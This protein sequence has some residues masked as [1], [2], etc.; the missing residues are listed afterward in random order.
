M[1]QRPILHQPP[2]HMQGPPMQPN[3]SPWMINQPPPQMGHHL[4][5]PPTHAPPPLMPQVHMP[6]G[7]PLNIPP[8]NAPIASVV[9]SLE[10]LLSQQR[11]LQE[12][13]QQSEQNL[14]AQQQVWILEKWKYR[15]N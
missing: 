15:N 11:K 3:S 9:S 12:Q 14:A 10:S 8:A 5:P 2:P 4:G 13:I 6:P 7:P 1:Q